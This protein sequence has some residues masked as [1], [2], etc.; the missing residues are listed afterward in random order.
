MLD[1]K[2]DSVQKQQPS[3]WPRDDS[4]WSSGPGQLHDHT[5]V[6]MFK[7]LCNCPL[8]TSRLHVQYCRQPPFPTAASLPDPPVLHSPQQES[9]PQAAYDPQSSVKDAGGVTL[10][11]MYSNDLNTKDNRISSPL[12]SSL[13]VS[14]VPTPALSPSPV[15]TH[16]LQQQRSRQRS[17]S[18]RMSFPAVQWCSAMVGLCSSFTFDAGHRSTLGMSRQSSA[19]AKAMRPGSGCCCSSSA[20]GVPTNS[21]Q[22]CL[23]YCAA[24]TVAAAVA[25]GAQLQTFVFLEGLLPA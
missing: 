1:L 7:L 25:C 3:A 8:G 14:P 20:S 5:C 12:S 9:F 24:A 2:C 13:G 17:M 11:A 4:G 23:G 22:T 10:P 16:S 18:L 15:K 21:R 19:P 6:Q